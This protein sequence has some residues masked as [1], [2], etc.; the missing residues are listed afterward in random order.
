MLVLLLLFVFPSENRLFLALLELFSVAYIA[1][2]RWATEGKTDQS[3]SCPACTG[4][5]V[6]SHGRDQVMRS[7]PSTVAGGE[8]ALGSTGVQFLA[9]QRGQSIS[10]PS[11]SL[12]VDA[13]SE[14]I[15][16]CE[17][18][19]GNRLGIVAELE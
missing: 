2:A 19:T 18:V 6:P 8:L 15:D 5:I 17:L 7:A 10:S 1:S 13:G 14:F 3:R 9:L 4:P 11:A 12:I 16:F